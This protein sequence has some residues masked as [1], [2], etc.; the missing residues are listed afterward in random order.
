MR[1]IRLCYDDFSRSTDRVRVC[2]GIP[3]WFGEKIDHQIILRSRTEWIDAKRFLR[4]L[5]IPTGPTTD[6]DTWLIKDDEMFALLLLS[7]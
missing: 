1:I 2:E 3:E 6:S 4:E 7:I 5:G